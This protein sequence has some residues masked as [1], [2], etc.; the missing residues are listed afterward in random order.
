MVMSAHPDELA[1]VP[2]APGTPPGPDLLVVDGEDVV[3][4]CRLSTSAVGSAVAVPTRRAG[5]RAQNFI[6]ISRAEVEK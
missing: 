3:V 4:A 2:L 1:P 5:M 6:V